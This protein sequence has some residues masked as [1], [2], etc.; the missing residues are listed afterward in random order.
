[1][2]DPETTNPNRLSDRRF[3]ELDSLRGVAAL[4]VVFHHFSRILPDNVLHLLIRT[5]ARLLIAGHQAV[6]LF[7]L[8]SGFVLTLP[9]KKKNRLAYIPFLLKR[10]CRIY[11]PYLGALALAV[12]CDLSFPNHLPSTNYWLNFTWS[13]PVTARLVLQHVLFLGNYDWS[14]STPPSGRSSTR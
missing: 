1:V 8:L 3:H 13:Q 12:L 11:L 10:V 5:P 4:T 9:Y 2:A 14:S 6:I 7:F